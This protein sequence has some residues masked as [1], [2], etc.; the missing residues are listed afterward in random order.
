[1]SDRP[2]LGLL[3]DSLEEAYQ[4]AVLAGVAAAAVEHDANLLCFAGGVL[5]SPHRFGAQRNAIY[6]IAGPEN[7]DGLLVMSGT[8]GNHVGLAELVRFCE[9]FRPLPMCSIAVAL[10]GVSSVL[11][12]NATG[13]RDAIVHL[14]EAHGH[15]RIAFIRGPE[16]N[17][18]A[19]RRYRVYRDVLAERGV[20]LDPELVAVGHFQQE[21]GK[22]AIDVLFGE[23][24]LLPQ[25]IVA[26][27][28]SMALG[29]ID[30]L[31]ARG[32]RVPEDVAVVGFDDVEEARFSAAPLTTVR[33][34]LE[35][36]GRRA[37]ELLLS[38]IGGR[39]APEQVVLHT[40][41]VTR[42]SCGCPR[43]VPK[44]EDL[45]LLEE[46]IRSQ[47]EQ[48]LNVQRW[49]R[50]LAETGE[51]LL[52]TFDVGLLAR[53]AA[54]QFPQL[55]IESCFLSLYRGE[56]PPFERS[57]LVLAWERRG[58]QPD[59][60]G[61]RSFASRQLA[62]AGILPLGRRHTFVIEP[63]FF[64]T[65]QLG[66]ALF[67][68][69]PPEGVIYE[70]LRD[71]I[72]GALK[73]ALLVQQ[74]VEKD[75]ERQR[76]LRYIVDVT[77]DMHRVQ[78]LEDLFGN[79]LGQVTGLLGA[80]ESA[81]APHSPGS[82][83]PPPEAEGFLGM[84]EED[85]EL[86]IKAST[87]LFAGKTRLEGALD[88]RGI[89]RVTDAL[90]SGRIQIDVLSTIVPLRVGETTLGLIYLDRPAVSNQDVELLEIFSNQATA[91]I[92]NTQLYEM[93]ALDPLTGVHA[94]RFFEQWLRREVK[95]A[96]RS[97]QPV[98]LIMLDMDGMKL[99]ND[100]SGHLA[101]DQALSTVGKV[102]R[103]ACRENDVIG[104]Y[105]GDEF[106]VVLPQTT[107]E[108]A[109]L[110]A[111][112]ILELLDDKQVLSA[113]G[114]RLPIRS[115]L[116]VSTLMPHRF[117]PG[118]LGQLVASRYFQQV[119]TAVIQRADEA[120]YEAKKRGGARLCVGAATSWLPPSN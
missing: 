71:Q 79:I 14:L 91:A 34:P 2:T 43:G 15:R 7:I 101:G 5:R 26:A 63:L 51:A 77:P 60:A 52:T 39:K 82:I 114:Q 8:L 22:A 24:G 59:H 28:D 84:V 64:K 107:S 110:V 98:S 108:G 6:E 32:L 44:P 40:E 31:A 105:G 65:D 119:A 21:S 117:A 25:A 103:Q 74:V 87:P 66:F 13:M 67:E 50:A 30:A 19:E 57:R 78:P 68:M 116:G 112:R 93:A 89:E 54:E 80:V 72:S 10:P 120:L 1:L 9:R 49:A 73:G 85:G 115:S 83:P 61:T 88:A 97:Q 16:A 37:A 104:R 48:R 55:G 95:T 35:Q 69:G 56:H 113:D 111:L 23:R 47:A 118:E 70:A 90:S 58:E 36:Q 42:S 96:L 20:P 38:Q 33:Q 41:L 81:P 46:A 53:V 76:L 3:V 86:E 12:D 92:Q 18:E 4:N 100:S 27:S 94:R 75:R 62:P 45:S 17:E 99:I 29:A 102:L 106:A 11:V 109:Q